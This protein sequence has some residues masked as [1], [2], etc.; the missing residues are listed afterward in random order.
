[1]VGAGL[2]ASAELEMTV[3]PF[4]IRGVSLIGVSSSSAPREL[5]EAVW[6]KLGGAWKP[7][8]LDAICTGEIGL[9]GLPAAFDTLLAGGNHGRTV[10]RID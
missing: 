5:R 6:E 9:D 1:V 2:A 7:A 10:V 4:I 8:H 3:M